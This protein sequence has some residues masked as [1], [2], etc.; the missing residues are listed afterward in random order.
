MLV[1][2]PAPAAALP[3]RSARTLEAT[4][5]GY[6]RYARTRQFE[7]YLANPDPLGRTA[8]TYLY[9]TAAP[10]RACADAGSS[11]DRRLRLPTALVV[12]LVIVVGVGLVVLWAHS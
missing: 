11:A 4:V 3:P 9:E 7:R 12:G 6:L 8:T 5:A 2:E 10:A 1:V